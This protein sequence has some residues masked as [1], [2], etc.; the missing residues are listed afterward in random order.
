MICLCKE[1]ADEF[2][3]QFRIS[4]LD[5]WPLG[6]EL[7]NMVEAHNKTRSQDQK[8]KRKSLLIQRHI[9]HDLRP[10]ANPYLLKVHQLLNR[11]TLKSKTNVWTMR[12]TPTY[13]KG[14][15][16]EVA[17]FP[18]HPLFF[19]IECLVLARPTIIEWRRHCSD[20]LLLWVVTW[21]HFVHWDITDMTYSPARLCLK[22]KACLPFHF[23]PPES[24]SAGDKHHLGSD[25]W[26]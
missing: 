25:Q 18:Q 20:S 2:G 17:D 3:S 5:S 12:N 26:H 10:L 24:R 9:P 8:A 14:T 4:G 1:M 11:A 19:I 22:S 6:L 15:E 23:A 16:T 7:H 21:L 13:T